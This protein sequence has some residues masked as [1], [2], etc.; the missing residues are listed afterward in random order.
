MLESFDVSFCDGVLGASRNTGQGNGFTGMDINRADAVLEDIVSEQ[1]VATDKGTGQGD[2]EDKFFFIS[3]FAVN[4]LGD[5][6]GTG[7][8]GVGRLNGDSDSFRRCSGRI[9]QYGVVFIRCFLFY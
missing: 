1:L 8:L 3:S 7:L 2:V 5:R 6:Q 4:D 9:G